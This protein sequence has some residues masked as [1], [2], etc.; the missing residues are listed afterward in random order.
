MRSARPKLPKPPLKAF[1]VEVR[2]TPGPLWKID[3]P[4]SVAGFYRL[5]GMTV[6]DEAHLVAQA[7]S[8]LL[9]EGAI[10]D[11]IE[12][13]WVPDFEGDDSDL[14]ETVGDPS[15]PGMWYTSGYAFFGSEGDDADDR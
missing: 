10:L 9:R 7:T 6:H 11:R 14:L 1:L 13:V 3:A 15:V 2:G 4:S 12:Q 8:E 5:L